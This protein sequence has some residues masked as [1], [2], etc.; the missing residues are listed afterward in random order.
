MPNDD[1]L[2]EL[3]ER[4][5]ELLARGGEVTP[6]DLGVDADTLA[7]VATLHRR[8]KAVENRLGPVRLPDP[9]PGVTTD[10]YTTTR[11]LGSGGYGDVFHTDDRELGRAVA[12]KVPRPLRAADDVVSARLRAE[13]VLMG[14][15]DHPGIPAVHSLGTDRTGR[16]FYTMRLIDGSTLADEISRLHLNLPPKLTA[17]EFG[18]RLRPLLR[19]F[20][21][22]C[23]AV[24]Y[25]H[26]R[27]VI[28]RDLKPL[29][30]M[31]GRFDETLVMDWGL[32]RGVQSTTDAE[33]GAAVSGIPTGQ[34]LG[35]VGTIGYIAPEQWAADPAI[36]HRADVYSL[37]A[38]LYHLLAGRP[39]LLPAE[40][41]DG[42]RAESVRPLRGSR[43][44]P[45]LVAVCE[46]AMAAA[47]AG[48]Y[49]SAEELSA[50]VQAWLDDRPVGAYREPLIDRAARWTRRHPGIV[51]A[52]V[53]AVVIAAVGGT[54]GAVMSLDSLR[55]SGAGWRSS[56][57][58]SAPLTRR[59]FGCAGRPRSS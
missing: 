31:L 54:V 40:L 52:A 23:A 33:K 12:L 19:R 11:L 55:N 9:R 4:Y 51:S 42:F 36:D 44:P 53:A 43:L 41:G 26:N 1:R 18:D 56:A 14:K 7:R 49:A 58:A 13:A 32:A 59:T 17:R 29:N 39:S 15:L 34:T 45:P 50:D 46:K 57:G 22:V 3:L 6:A 21:A 20:V 48:R 38:I 37:G 8:S 28:H 35:A 24:A 25:A 16:P 27:G 30:V 5:R 47:P 2:F 10:R